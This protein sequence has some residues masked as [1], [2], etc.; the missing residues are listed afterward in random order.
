[1]ANGAEVYVF[2]KGFR[3]SSANLRPGDLFQKA[4][5]SFWQ[6]LADGSQVPFGGGGSV[7]GV[8]ASADF[9]FTEQTTPGIYTA[10]FA[11]PDGAVVTDGRVYLLTPW[12]CD[13][14]SLDMGDADEATGYLA[15]L[16]FVSDLSNTPYDATNAV[17]NVFS[18]AGLPGNDAS[19]S[20]SY[21]DGAYFVLPA[22][23]LSNPR[24]GVLSGTPPMTYGPANGPI[25]MTLTT[26][27]ASP[28]VVATGT[29]LVKIVYF[30]PVTAVAASFA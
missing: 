5:G 17:G 9:I 4:D 15:G 23:G 22:I 20:G 25:T 30:L 18:A 24:G 27:I 28:P 13:E 26:T 3:Q 6:V 12:A 16:T 29:A 1:M 10:T 2:Q 8:L 21:A 11:P 7:P 14:A 19:A